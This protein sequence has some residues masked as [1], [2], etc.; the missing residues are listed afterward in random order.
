MW[1]TSMDEQLM[2][3]DVVL[4]LRHIKKSLVTQVIISLTTKSLIVLFSQLKFVYYFNEK[5]E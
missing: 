4:L 3:Q 2:D 5:T 1:E